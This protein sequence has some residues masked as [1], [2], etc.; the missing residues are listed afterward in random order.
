MGKCLFVLVLLLSGTAYAQDSEPS[1]GPLFLKSMVGEGDFFAPWGIGVDLYTMQQ[2]YGIRAL[3][4]DLPGLEI[5]DPSAIG[6]SNEVQHYDLKL[7][8]WLTPFL[9]VYGLLGQLDANTYVDF[10]N[11][12]IVGLPGGL[13]TLLVEYDG[14]VYGLGANLVYGTDRWFIAVNSTWT[15]TD[16]SGDF[17]SSVETFTAQPRI[18]LVFDSWVAWVGAMYLNTEE[19]HSGTIDLPLPGLPPVPFYVELESQDDWNYGVG[20]GKVFGPRA[21]MSF[22]V[23]FG[24]RKHTLLNLTYRF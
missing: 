23:G 4:F 15:D 17:D 12:P 20:V 2:D 18:G 13:G 10:S 1:G 8:V 6:V 7:D 22:E 14:T 5:P 3:E 19:T 9:N 16:L 21:H 11:V 24:D